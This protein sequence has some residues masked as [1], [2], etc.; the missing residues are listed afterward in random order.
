M[1]IESAIQTWWA[2]TPALN[3]ALDVANVVSDDQLEAADAPYVNV[4]VS[5]EPYT[6]TTSGQIYLDTVTFEVHYDRDQASNGLALAT[7]IQNEWESFEA[8]TPQVK[9]WCPLPG[10][11]NKPNED[12]GGHHWT[13]I[14]TVKHIRK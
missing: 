13:V 9:S 3:N 6:R 5:D 2:S 11:K 12:S 7:A 4:I 8:D 10:D 14:N 1:T